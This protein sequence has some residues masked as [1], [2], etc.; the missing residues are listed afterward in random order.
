MTK[1]KDQFLKF[2][3]EWN[4]HIGQ[5]KMGFEGVN[6]RLPFGER[7]IEG[8]RL[9]E[10]ASSFNLITAKTFSR[11]ETVTLLH[12]ILVTFHS[13]SHLVTFHYRNK[14]VISS[15]ECVSQYK[16]MSQK[17]NISHTNI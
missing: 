7:N 3:G 15:I 13:N 4:G 16:C 1:I 9:F 11:N 5:N 8:D 17:K 10:F 6:D 12:F 14:K 2:S